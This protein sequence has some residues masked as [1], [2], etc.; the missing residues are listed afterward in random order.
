M[1]T[2]L[3]ALQELQLV[4]RGHALPNMVIPVSALYT[5]ISEGI[6]ST[7]YGKLKSR[8]TTNLSNNVSSCIV[9]IG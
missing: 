5:K 6:D 2:H 3:R 9:S 7:N 1:D 8:Y 4:K